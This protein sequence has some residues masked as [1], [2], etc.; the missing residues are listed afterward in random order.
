M[1]T[2]ADLPLVFTAT[3]NQL[4]PRL[5]QRISTSDRPSLGVMAMTDLQPRQGKEVSSYVPL[6]PDL[7][8]YHVPPDAQ[9]PV[10]GRLKHFLAEWQKI[11]SDQWVLKVIEHGF[12]LTFK[13]KAPPLS[14][15]PRPVKLPKNWEKRQALLQAVEDLKTKA[16]VKISPYPEK[17]LFSH[18]FVVSKKS[19]GWRP[20]IDLSVLNKF[21]RVP[22]F[23]METVQ[24]IRSQLQIGEFVV[25][26]DL[27]DAYFHVPIQERFQKYLKFCVLGIVYQFVALCFGLA[28]APRAFTMVMRAVVKFVRVLGMLLHAYLD[29]WLL[30]NRCPLVLMDQLR[31]LLVLLERL[32]ILVNFPKADLNPRQIF[33]FLG[34][35]FNLVKGLVFPTQEAMQKLKVWLEFFRTMKEVPARA[36]LSFLGLL[37]HMGDLVPLG[38]LNTRPLQWYLKC[39]YR[40]HVDNL[41]KIVPL[42]PAFF[43]CLQFW[44]CEENLTKGSPLH[45]P[46][47]ICQCS[48]MPVN[49]VGELSATESLQQIDGV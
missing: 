6:C 26:L 30:R 14:E 28:S 22:H 45:L 37:N 15:E 13:G 20:I 23:K 21:L 27:K 9:L 33:V 18:L 48:R 8:P 29:D 16:A 5:T 24:S 7:L 41:Y 17:A 34:V 39:F 43:Q 40:P 46:Q 4:P 35:K 3:D 31:Q 44:D 2:P 38:R 1:E 25:T 11:T 36:L 47:E 42:R 32:G 10:G 19:G 49:K 12:I